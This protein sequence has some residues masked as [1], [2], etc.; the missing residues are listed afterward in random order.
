MNLKFFRRVFGFRLPWIPKVGDECTVRTK[1]G[2]QSG[3]V[4]KVFKDD[5]YSVYV[6]NKRRYVHVGRVDLWR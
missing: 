2:D 6:L 4:S 1:W 5:R 3:M